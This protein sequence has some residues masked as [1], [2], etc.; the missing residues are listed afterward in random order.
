METTTKI[1]VS[2]ILAI[3]ACSIFYYIRV[4]DLPVVGETEEGVKTYDSKDMQS[5]YIQSFVCLVIVFSVV[6]T[7]L[8]L[9]LKDN[10][11]DK[12]LKNMQTGEPDF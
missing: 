5:L 9:T 4:S 1:A 10:I 7:A 11:E 3:I 2:F 12:M 8:T 6:Y